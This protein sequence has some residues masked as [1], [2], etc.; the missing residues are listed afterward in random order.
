MS[1]FL[2]VLIALG[3]ALSTAGP[4][5]G[6]TLAVD[7]YQEALSSPSRDSY[8]P[9]KGDPTV[10]A[11]HY[12][13]DLT[14]RR[15]ARVLR[16]VA[17]IHLRAARTAAHLRL[18]LSGRLD[19]R[20]VGVGGSRA[21]FTH[22]RNHLVVHAPVTL[23][24]RETVRVV[25]RGTPG[26]ARG[27]AT[28]RDIARVGM[29]VTPDGQLWTMQEPFG[30]FTWFPVNDHP[31]DKALYDVRVSVPR[32][33]VGI[34]NG[35][36]T[37]RRTT[38]RRT[39]TTWANRDPMASYLTTVA[40][41]PYRVFRQTGPHGLP[42]SYWVPRDRPELVR[43]L[44][45]SPAAVRWLERRLGRYPF[46]RFGVVLTPS[47][48]AMETQTLVT[49]GVHNYVLGPLYVRTTVVHELAHHWYG[50]S[51][52]PS[53]WRDVWMNEGMATYLDARWLDEHSERPGTSWRWTV[54]DWTQ[55][56]P[57]LREVYG[58]PGAY[59]RDQFAAGN[60]YYS[61]ALM[62]E[63]LRRRVGDET[64][65]RLVR[66]WPRSRPQSNADRDALVTWWE[67]GSGE[68]LAGFFDT[69]LDSADSPA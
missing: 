31:S 38:G 5:A 43:P 50:N 34:S 13:L 53:D 36:L 68:P 26:T 22:E 56:D 18:D 12:D 66:S 14:W 45:R 67:T 8:Y 49:F 4:A 64:F 35:E 2:A 40:V 1:R 48:S 6:A 25:Y 41:G 52:T 23:G 29:R 46:D 51:V 30:A 58:P 7:Q 3:L 57:W 20:R 47:G 42:M 63:R 32:G 60:V 59:E 10:D 21:P 17:T 62:W 24:T 39:V 11:L 9:G 54:R 69:W 16:G 61:V 28:R 27:P 55:S 37:S 15:K 19:V 44:L 65:D 33:W